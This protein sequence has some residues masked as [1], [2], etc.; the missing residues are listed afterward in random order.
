MSKG[1]TEFLMEHMAKEPISFHMPG[2]KGADFYKNFGYDDFLNKVMDMDITEIPGADNLFQTESVIKDVMK[3]YQK[4]YGSRTTYLLINGSSAGIVASILATVCRDEKLIVA[5][6]CHKSVFNGV[7]LGGIEPVYVYPEIVEK[8]SISGEV[9]LAEIVKA[10]DENPEAKAVILPS[11][12]YYGIC[13]DIKGIAEECHKRGMIL[14]VDQAHGAHLKL[15]D[16]LEK[17]GLDNLNFPKSAESQGADIV[18]N[19]THKTLASWTQTAVLN[20]M[21]ERVDLVEL[22]DRLQQIE[23]SSPSYPLMAS[24]EINADILLDF[25][26]RLAEYWKD[27]LESFYKEASRITGLEIVKAENMDPTKIN[28][29]MSAFG[30]NG[31]KLEKYFMERGIFLEL[32]AGNIAML[33]SGIGNK[34]YDF[35][36]VIKALREISEEFSRKDLNKE[37]SEFFS[38]KLEWGGLPKAW[39][40]VYIDDAVGKTAAK[41]IIPYPPGVP[42]CCPG[43]ILSKELIEHIKKIR[44][45]GEKVI[46]VTEDLKV[47]VSKG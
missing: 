8:Y 46:G 39:E 36:V 34:R 19:S 29:D 26:D 11:P 17:K 4:I 21:T 28:L 43:E 38:G 13:S 16:D 18:I 15:F 9:S 47:L 41:P 20:V 7:S 23:S 22:E 35:D 12:N 3:K 5:R 33:M 25:G 31:E 2:H 10:M 32:I 6:N 30:F 24:L 14:I 42:V 37:Q 27:N 40:A 44:S 45:A 1:L